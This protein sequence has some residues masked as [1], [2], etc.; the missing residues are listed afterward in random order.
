MPQV[1]T[2]RGSSRRTPAR[3]AARAAGPRAPAR[4]EKA[5]AAAARLALRPRRGS[6]SAEARAARAAPSLRGHLW[7]ERGPVAVIAPSLR[8]SPSLSPW[9]TR[10]GCAAR[11]ANRRAP[12]CATPEPRRVRQK[13]LQTLVRRRARFGAAGGRSTPRAIDR[14]R[15]QPA[16]RSSVSR[17]PASIRAP[18]PGT[19]RRRRTPDRRAMPAAL[20]VVLLTRARRHL[21]RSRPRHRRQ[22][23]PPVRRPGHL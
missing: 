4:P 6:G 23:H 20:Q 14:V 13:M 3:P 10:A 11:S 18:A 2:M 12:A 21:Q 8:L 16:R 19:S 7:G 17:T 5:A 1:P 22:T 9:R 15:A